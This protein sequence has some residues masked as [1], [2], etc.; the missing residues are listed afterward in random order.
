[1]LDDLNRDVRRVRHTLNQSLHGLRADD[2]DFGRFGFHEGASPCPTAIC[3][4]Q[5]LCLV[6][7]YTLACIMG[8][9]HLDR[10]GGDVRSRNGDMFFARQQVTEDAAL[11]QPIK[12]FKGQQTQRRKIPPASGADE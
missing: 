9:E 2:V 12:D 11:V 10:C 7:D 3:G 5:H 8:I 1:M 6:N 4:R